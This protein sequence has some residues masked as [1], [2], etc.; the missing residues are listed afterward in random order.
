MET[1]AE[2]DFF[3]RSGP[4]TVKLPAESAREHIRTRFVA[5]GDTGGVG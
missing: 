1:E 2:G 3:V 5:G 4:E